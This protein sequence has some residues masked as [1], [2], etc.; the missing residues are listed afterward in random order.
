MALNALVHNSLA[1]HS[2]RFKAGHPSFA[3]S[4]VKRKPDQGGLYGH[5]PLFFHATRTIAL[6]SKKQRDVPPSEVSHETLT[7][8]HW[9]AGPGYHR[10][11]AFDNSCGC[12]S[13]AHRP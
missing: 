3:I 12:E 5:W 1:G 9:P 4:G 2:K 10:G 7:I 6:S 11:D 8:F 13:R